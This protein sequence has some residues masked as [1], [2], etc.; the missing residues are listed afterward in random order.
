MFSFESNHMRKFLAA[1]SLTVL[2]AGSIFAA[3]RKYPDDKC[4]PGSH[5]VTKTNTNTTSGNASISGNAKVVSGGASVSHS[6]TTTETVK[7]CRDNKDSGVK[8]ATP[9][10]R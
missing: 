10:R 3:D 9:K 5:T 4:P 7:V 2:C 1:L 8:E 6:R